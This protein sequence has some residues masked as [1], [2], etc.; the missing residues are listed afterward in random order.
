MTMSSYPDRL[1]MLNSHS[2]F[3]GLSAKE[4]LLFEA[5]IDVLTTKCLKAENY[6]L[7]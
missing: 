7:I 6:T 1:N 2:I 5:I 3:A 4:T